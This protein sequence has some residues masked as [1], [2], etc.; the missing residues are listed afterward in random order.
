MLERLL[1]SRDRSETSGINEVAGSGE[2]RETKEKNNKLF[3]QRVKII[4]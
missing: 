2:S 1:V 3:D 4:Q